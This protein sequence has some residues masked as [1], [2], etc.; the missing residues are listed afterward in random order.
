MDKILKSINKEFIFNALG[1]DNHLKDS[2]SRLR[3]WYDHIRK[4]ANRDS[5]DIFEFGV[6]RGASLLSVAILLK[7]LKSS[8]KVYGFDSFSGFPSYNDFDDLS[9]FEKFEGVHFEEDLVQNF[10]TLKKIREQS[11]N[12]EI[13]K[14]NIS[15]VG[16][17]TDTS[18]KSL[19][20]KIEY[21]GLDNI[22]L[23]E[24]SFSDTLPSFFKEFQGSISSVN[25][26]CDLY[27]GYKLALPHIWKNLR[28][29]GYVHLD[30]YYSL[31]FPGARI[32]CNEF[33]KKKGI[34]PQK[35]RVREGE[36]ER[37]YFIK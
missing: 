4:N 18:L 27:D 16:E 29:G 10:K 5:G 26:D 25:I 13:D 33:F 15:S 35:Q 28:E 19:E 36:F 6:F 22:V 34:E 17:F 14:K 37:W 12:K 2:S 3:F 23:I 32:A 9:S 8:K 20:D 30:E 11:L 7:Q 1:I 21:L 31:K 24:G